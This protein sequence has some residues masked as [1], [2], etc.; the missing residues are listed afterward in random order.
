MKVFAIGDL[1]LSGAVDKPMDIFGS[2]WEHH[3]RRIAHAWRAVVS[4][5][6]LVLIPG[7]F[8]WAMQLQ[9]ARV[10]LEYLEALPGVKVMIRG[11]HDYWWNSVSKV[12]AALPPSVRVIQNDCFSMGELH[13]AGT[14]GWVCPGSAGFAPEDQKIYDREVGRLAL[15]LQRLPVG[16]RRIAMLHYPPLNEARAPSG[17]TALL[18]QYGV[19]IVLYGHL[20]GKSCRGGFEGTREGITYHLVSADHIGFAPKLILELPPA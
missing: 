17:F 5:E 15:S 2:A 14:R 18:E 1:H 10:D 13:I 4:P 19:E 12:R 16:G 8:S 20:H 3:A 11:N 7:D 9:Q 6:D